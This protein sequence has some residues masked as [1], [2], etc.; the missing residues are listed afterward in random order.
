MHVVAFGSVRDCKIGKH[1]ASVAAAC[2]IL[3][4]AE[5]VPRNAFAI[6]GLLSADANG[7]ESPPTEASIRTQ[8]R[9]LALAVH[10]DKTSTHE[11]EG[12]VDASQT[13]GPAG[14]AAL[15]AAFQHLVE[16]RDELI[17]CLRC[18]GEGYRVSWVQAKYQPLHTPPIAVAHSATSRAAL[19]RDRAASSA[20]QT[21]D[22]VKKDMRDP[23]RR[24][25]L[26]EFDGEIL[27][28]LFRRRPGDVGTL[29]NAALTGHPPSSHVSTCSVPAAPKRH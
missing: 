22:M 1:M 18:D 28:K 5:S 24:V 19:K 8:F 4:R 23:M 17:A 14:H 9:R 26:Q 2:T 7:S 3:K 27:E 20:T 12:V 21:G 6:L 13:S 15:R 10:P 16:A 29:G 25:R 11:H